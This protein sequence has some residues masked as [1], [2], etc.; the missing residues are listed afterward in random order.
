MDD[1]QLYYAT[2]IIISLVSYLYDDGILL[3]W[4]MLNWNHTIQKKRTW[5]WLMVI[6]HLCIF[7]KACHTKKLGR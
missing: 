6:I 3:I 4:N 1:I 2:Y 7:T 5:L